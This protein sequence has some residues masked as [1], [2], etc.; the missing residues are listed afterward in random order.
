MTTPRALSTL[1]I[2]R[3]ASRPPYHS[4]CLFRSRRRLAS[5]AARPTPSTTALRPQSTTPSST[6]PA[7]TGLRL[8]GHQRNEN[9]NEICQATQQ[10][11]WHSQPSSHSTKVYQ[12]DDVKGLVDSPSKERILIDVREPT[13]FT[14]GA[15]PT[16]LNVPISSQPDALFLPAEEFEDRFGFEKPAADKEVVFY[17]K[18]GVRSSAAAMMARQ[19][20]YEK[21]GEYRG[22]WLDWIKKGGDGRA[23]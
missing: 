15:I 9:E 1:S 4:R 13:E 19:C 5:Q 23:S 8:R 2:P 21:V 14:A 11:R 20:G 6:I 7:A 10:L 16:A 17:C 22:S 18:A 3:A 12:F